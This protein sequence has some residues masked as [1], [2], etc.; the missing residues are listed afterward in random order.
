[1]EFPRLSTTDCAALGAALVGAGLS[2]LLHYAP[3][4]SQLLSG[5]LVAAIMASVLA[6]YAPGSYAAYKAAANRKSDVRFW[7]AF[8]GSSLLFRPGLYTPEGLLWRKKLLWWYCAYAI[9]VFTGVT[10]CWA[11]GLIDLNLGPVPRK[12]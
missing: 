4:A 2:A 5:L 8:Q 9:F 11:A 12:P 6:F 10:I 1:M 7:T 3:P